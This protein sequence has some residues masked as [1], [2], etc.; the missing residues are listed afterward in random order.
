MMSDAT[1]FKDYT[2]APP[3]T[4]VEICR[5]GVLTDVRTRKA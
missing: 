2:S 5:P 3:G 1:E 4:I